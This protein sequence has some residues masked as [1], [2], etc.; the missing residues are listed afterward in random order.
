MIPEDELA[1][2][3]AAR[4]EV[5]AADV[6]HHDDSTMPNPDQQ[7]VEFERQLVREAWALKRECPLLLDAMRDRT[8]PRPDDQFMLMRPDVSKMSFGQLM[9]FRMGQDSVTQW[10]EILANTKEQ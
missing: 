9:A 2:Y 4:A 5:E 3:R 10:I 7:Q 1:H 8:Y 6:Q